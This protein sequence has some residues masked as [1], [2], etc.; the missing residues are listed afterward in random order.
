MYIIEGSYIMLKT[1]AVLPANIVEEINHYDK[2]KL[3]LD[4]YIVVNEITLKLGLSEDEEN[5]LREAAIYPGL[6]YYLK[7]N[8]Y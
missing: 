1:K 3:L 2:F 8:T 7:S 4:R 6:P 5:V